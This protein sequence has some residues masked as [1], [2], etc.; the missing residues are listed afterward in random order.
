MGSLYSF[1]KQM[2][3]K[4]I[5]WVFKPG[6]LR[7]EVLL[8]FGVGRQLKPGFEGEDWAR[9]WVGTGAGLSSHSSVLLLFHFS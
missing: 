1:C 2:A 4:S 6:G 3:T 9:V 7:E 8:G 5:G